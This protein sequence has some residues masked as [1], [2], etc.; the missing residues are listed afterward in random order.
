MKFK[1]ITTMQRNYL[2]LFVLICAN[3]MHAQTPFFTE[4]FETNLNGWI[5]ETTNNNPNPAFSQ[6]WEWSNDPG[7][8]IAGQDTFETP[9]GFAQYNSDAN[10]NFAHVARL[11]SPT[12]DCSSH[13]AVYVKIAY[14]Y[15]LYNQES[16]AFIGVKNDDMNDFEYINILTSNLV[17]DLS[18]KRY[19]YLDISE[20]AGNQENVQLQI[21]WD[22]QWEYVF[23]VDDIELYDSSESLNDYT[24]KAFK[25]PN[26]L[27]PANTKATINLG[28]EVEKIGL[29]E[30]QELTLNVEI[31]KDNVPVYN[32]SINFS[33][34]FER[35]DTLIFPETFL[36]E[37]N[38]FYSVNYELQGL[39]PDSY[40]D[41][42]FDTSTITID[43]NVFQKD[44]ILLED[45]I[46]PAS[47]PNIANTSTFWEIGNYYHFSP[48]DTNVPYV[49]C[50]VLF[51][52]ASVDGVHHPNTS[53]FVRLYEI[54]TIDG[55][56][57][58]TTQLGVN[59]ISLMNYENYDL[60]DVNVFDDNGDP[61]VLT[62]DQEYLIAIELETEVWMPCAFYKYQ[63]QKNTAVKS[64]VDDW[65]CGGF[66]TQVTGV[67]RMEIMQNDVCTSVTEELEELDVFRVFPNPG[68]DQIH[69]QLIESA[70]R[71]EVRIELFDFGG[72][73]V[74]ERSVD[75]DL[76][77]LDVGHLSKGTYFLRVE[78]ESGVSVE[79]VAL[80]D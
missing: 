70:N 50:N 13:D 6:E 55:C 21:R 33:S 9:L 8:I 72:K 28:C 80:V 16:K 75:T 1:K 57:F 15:V 64:G 59:T 11:T 79:K 44:N 71:E 48:V 22:G 38:G 49:L 34:D 63:F 14:Q 45:N 73:L 36:I 54:T 42:N 20:F 69:V 52:I 60:I 61:I 41:D 56:E 5:D 65:L 43:G 7:A 19:L 39:L 35:L 53:A 24:I 58:E 74:L 10:G 77:S 37:E 12:I 4:N 32:N 17:E 25:T 67:I 31:L 30:I 23:R 66:L 40:P 29:D 3:V 2:I 78:S 47:I 26:F 46:E 51:S 68:N 18:A 62:N 27:Q 76:F